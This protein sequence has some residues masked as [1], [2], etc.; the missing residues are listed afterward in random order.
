MIDGIRCII[1]NTS[2]EPL[3]VVPSRRGLVLV[4]EGKA[5]I[6]EAHPT[7]QIRSVRQVWPLP[8]QV[9]LTEY[10]RARP[11]NLV[12][13]QLTQRN[14]FVRDRYCCQYCGRTKADLHSGEFL[15]RD[16]VTPT[17]RGGK[18]HWSNVVTACNSCNNKKSDY[19]L[20]EANLYY[21]L[22]LLSKPHVP[23]AFEI[24]SRIRIKQPKVVN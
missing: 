12:P 4:I 1:L 2:Y 9:I 24:W 22:E 13:A 15:T 5:T 23:T 17:T 11:A 10:R 19:T 20:E 3:S 16:H 21:G 18:D 8:T 6:S 7:L 14:L